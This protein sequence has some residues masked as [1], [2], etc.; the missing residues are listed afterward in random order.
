M[1]KNWIATEEHSDEVQDVELMEVPSESLESDL[2][3]VTGLDK[4]VESLVADGEELEHDQEQV[5]ALA[6]N[7]EASL[8]E[9]GMDETAARATEI[10]A[11]SFCGKWGIQR[12]KVGLES[13]GTSDQRRHATQIAVESL[14]DA[15]A[16]MW[17]TF[18][19]WLKELVAKAREQLMKLTNAG[20]SMK[21]RAEKLEARLDK[22]LGVQDKK[23]VEGSFTKQL[24][25]DEKVDYQECLSFANNSASSVDSI[26]KAV[27]TAIDET[28]KLVREPQLALPGP[29]TTNTDPLKG[30]EFGKKTS[31]KL[32]VPQG[33]SDVSVKAL[34]GNTYLL[35]YTAN[36]TSFTKFEVAT[37]KVKDGKLP[38][39]T[40]DQ[41]KAGAKALYTI[42]EVL[43]NKLKAFR[44]TNE[45]MDKLASDVKD[46]KAKDKDSTSENREA[47]KA[48]LAQ[49]RANVNTAKAAERAVTTSLKN[50]G[51]GIAGYVAASISAYK[52]A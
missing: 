10:A 23:E 21:K 4:D 14:K 32:G 8:E 11:E 18:V 49:A 19:K 5:E 47:T 13:F 41:C 7:A 25:V 12:K 50:A 45:K 34:P 20:K 3:E 46:A 43:E 16:G 39:L 29:G 15:A 40:A 48:A 52:A 38:T 27:A 37:D 28:G 44:D 9:D 17:D 36:G 51:A 42:G 31:K 26:G 6:D 35:S 2:V 24:A 33:A 22:G 1:R 30:K